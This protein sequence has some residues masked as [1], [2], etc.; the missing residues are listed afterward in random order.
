MSKAVIMATWDDVPHL[1][2]AD[3]A[4]MLESY[5]PYQRDARSKGVPQLGAGAI[6]PVPESDFV[7]PPFD[8][9]K[10]W[11]RGYGFDVGWKW[12]AAAFMAHDQETDCVY[13]YDAYKRA[14]AE[15]SVHAAAIKRRGAFLP[16][17]IDPAAR[18]RAQKDGEQLLQ[19]YRDLGLNLLIAINTVEAALYDIWE[20]M[21]QGRF[22]VFST[23][24]P[25]LE[26]V[27]LYRRDEKGNIVKSNDHLMDA[28]RY[29]LSKLQHWMLDPDYLKKMGYAGGDND[30]GDYDPYADR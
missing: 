26:E 9:P 6:Y 20:R 29:G 2:P 14:Q 30:R 4:R 16:G 11:K 13:L 3:K 17:A 1:K 24:V 28:K 10:H 7:V 12:T 15:P 21:S 18:G 5:P 22:K 8:V 27:R 25:Y 23:C 19:N